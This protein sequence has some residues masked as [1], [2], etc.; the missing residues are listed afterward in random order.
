MYVDQFSRDLSLGNVRERTFG[1]IWNNA[2]VSTS[3]GARL[4]MLRGRKNRLGGKCARCRWLDI[5]NGNL[6]ADEGWP[7]NP[8]RCYLSQEEIS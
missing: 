1:E 7:G 4:A 5:C 2:D 3:A 8:S 6:P